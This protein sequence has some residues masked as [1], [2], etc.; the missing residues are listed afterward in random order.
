MARRTWRGEAKVEAGMDAM[1]NGGALG[2][3]YR[4]GEAVR[5][6]RRE[7]DRWSFNGIVL[8]ET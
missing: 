3:F 1:L 7:L 6:G 4:A 5:R 8:M 2:A